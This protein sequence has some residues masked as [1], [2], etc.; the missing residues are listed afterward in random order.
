MNSFHHGNSGDPRCRLRF[1][2]L[3]LVVD[4]SLQL[5][6]VSL[7][8]AYVAN[9]ASLSSPNVYGTLLY[10]PLTFLR[11]LL[12]LHPHIAQH[13]THSVFLHD[14]WVHLVQLFVI[15]RERLAVRPRYFQ[16]G[17]F[18]SELFFADV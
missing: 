16:T 3:V 11:L 1:H 17:N 18:L 13:T 9:F 5:I 10:S 2:V 4:V 15:F 6:R 14:V 8:I 12:A 7:G